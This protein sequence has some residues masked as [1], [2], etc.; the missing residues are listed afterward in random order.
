[1]RGRIVT[2]V[3]WRWDAA[4]SSYRRKTGYQN[5]QGVSP[6]P[7]DHND[8]NGQPV[9]PKNMVIQFT[10]YV[11]TGL[12]DASGEPVPEGKIVGEGE[13]WIFTEGKVIKGRWKKDSPE[14]VTAYTDANGQ[15]VK[16]TPGQTWLELPKP[17]TATIF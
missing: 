5:V 11:N 3:E 8:A 15:P 6:T 12:V 14:Q 7:T 13:A 2:N 1:F 16:L 10:E 9:A 17:G 4:S